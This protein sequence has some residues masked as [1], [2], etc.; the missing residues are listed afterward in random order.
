MHDRMQTFTSYELTQIHDASMDILSHTGIN[1]NDTETVYL[2][3]KKGF[4][5]EGRRVFI[6]E[7]DV[8]NALQTV[9]P[10]FTILAR[11]P[12]HNVSI[13]GDDFVFVPTAGAPNVV[14]ADGEQR[15]ATFKD[16][17]TCCKLVQTS[18]QIDLT[19]FLMVQPTDLPPHTAHLDMVYANI[20]M[21]DKAFES[22]T[23][24]GSAARDSLE[25]AKLIWGGKEKLKQQPVTL[26]IVNP[27]SPLQYSMEQATLITEMARYRQPVAITNMLLAGSTAPVSLP[28]LLAL[29]NAEIL[30]GLVLSQL[31]GPGTPVIYGATSAPLDMKTVISALGAPETVVIASAAIQLAKFYHLPCRTGGML[32]DS[33]CPDA[34]A[35]GEGALLMSTAVRNG[36]NFILHACGQMGSFISMSFEKW[37]IDEEVCANIRRMLVPLEISAQTIDVETIK[38]IGAGGHY[39]LHPKTFGQFRSLCQ[40]RL[41]NR[42]DYQKWRANGAKRIDQRAAEALAD[43]IAAYRK[44][45]IDEGLEQALAEYVNRRKVEGKRYSA[46]QPLEK[47]A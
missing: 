36:A 6:T 5:T 37:L 14:E 41:F 15:P 17:I 4:R 44:P 22:A 30:G 3:E 23:T 29:Q 46:D 11:N 42:R 28:G 2:F 18:D 25:M 8:S 24:S 12:D 39:L 9:P 43:R 34:Q 26:T 47:V 40:P 35:L 13:G 27:T 20:V 38:S 1:F 19:A 32:T 16:Y 10:R 33:H 31:A 45:P 7:S 21:C